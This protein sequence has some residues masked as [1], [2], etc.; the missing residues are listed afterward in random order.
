MQ[1]LTGAHIVY[2][3]DPWWNPHVEE[4]AVDRVHRIGQ[5]REVEVYRVISVNTIEQLIV[6]TQTQKRNIA[7]RVLTGRAA[8][9][10]AATVTADDL[11]DL[12][13]R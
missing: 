7:S 4:Q 12:L 6:D 13:L 1:T 10:H 11:R 8:D 2:L 3:C 9:S 5:T